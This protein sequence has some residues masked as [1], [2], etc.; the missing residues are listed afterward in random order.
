[1]SSPDLALVR[2]VS[3]AACA[4]LPV[5][6]VRAQDA[7]S[8]SS[9]ADRT[10]L[11]LTVDVG[12]ASAY[13][14]RGLNLAAESAQHDQRLVIQPSLAYAIPDTPLTVSYFSSYQATGERRA[15][16]DAAT[17]DEHDL[18]ATFEREISADLAFDAGLSAFVY[19]MATKASAGADVPV[20]LEPGLGVTWSTLL[21][22]SLSA[23]FFFGVQDA[24]RSS[25][26]LYVSPKLGKSFDVAS[27]V[28]LAGSVAYGI[29]AQE[30]PD[31]RHDVLVDVSAS[32]S[33][34][35]FFY[36]TPSVH[37]AWT[38]LERTSFVDEQFGWVGTN[39]GS[40]F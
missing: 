35:E 6:V 5:S 19:P 1:M 2:L 21:D 8:S 18:I 3:A 26:H 12:V 27:G 10:P 34:S 20:Y 24:L 40:S 23:S 36:V 22:V 16:V 33:P 4:L 32:F 31:N 13:G 17:S 28:T 30:S 9:E 39:V 29:K 37:W 25:R 14:W 11:G 38:N 15:R 7:V